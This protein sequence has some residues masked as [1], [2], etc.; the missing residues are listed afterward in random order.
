MEN[1][2]NS[3]MDFVKFI[4]GGLV[5]AEYPQIRS[6]LVERF[7]EIYGQDI[8]LSTGNADGIYVENLS[9]IIN[10]ILQT[11]K[12][13]YGQLNINQAQGLFLDNLCAL[14]GI[15]RKAATYSTANLTIKSE[16]TSDIILNVNNKLTFVDK[17]GLTWTTLINFGEEIIIKPNVETNVLVK[18]DTLGP[19]KA[20]K[21]WINSLIDT[22]IN[23][24]LINQT[25]DAQVGSYEEDDIQLR[26]R[27]NESISTKGIT[28]LQNLA[29]A[30]FNLTG[31]T[32]IKIYNNDTN[33]N[34]TANDTT[35]IKPHNIYVIIRRNSNINIS[36]S[37]IGSIIYEKL[38]PGIS[39][40]EGNTIGGIKK[41]YN[42]QQ[43]ILGIPYNVE[44]LPQVIKWKECQPVNDITIIITCTKKD[45][46]S[47]N[48]TPTLI[49]NNLK[50]YLANLQ[51]SEEFT[52]IDLINT[53]NNCDP[54]FRNRKTYVCTNVVINKNDSSEPLIIDNDTYYTQDTYID[55][56][57]Y[58]ISSSESG[59][60]LTLTINA[61][62]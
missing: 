8:D 14:S 42:Y 5:V 36:D 61:G 29:A 19:I 17:S 7:K 16:E 34:L 9:L 60:I 53:I 52:K 37:L 59:N 12:L 43:Y 13:M 6:M 41:S 33:E 1:N 58:V 25:K 20:P 46:Y 54:L 27:R 55:I 48:E 50:Y 35:I 22:S 30:L 3:T 21:G 51:I 44:S 23:L 57:D 24:T 18:C 10:N 28:V 49:L 62:V 4:N 47:S 38:T 45:N 40:T 11:L 2:Y 56:S 32:D 26:E 15:Y 39:T 31:I